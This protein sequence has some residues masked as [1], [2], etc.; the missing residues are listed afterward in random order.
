MTRCKCCCQVSALRAQ[1]GALE[2]LNGQLQQQQAA[3]LA[4]A[5]QTAEEAGSLKRLMDGELILLAC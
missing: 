5:Q 4:G 3:A 1:A 2:E